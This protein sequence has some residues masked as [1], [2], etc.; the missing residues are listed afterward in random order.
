MQDM[1]IGIDI[2]GTTVKIGFINHIGEIIEKWE[3]KTNKTNA[4][5]AIVDDI[6]NAINH[7]FTSANIDIKSVLGIGVG[8][9]GFIDSE[10]GIVFEAVNIGWKNF[11]LAG[12][13]T[14]KSKL[15]VFVQ[16]DANI[17]ALGENWQGAGNQ[18]KNIIAVTLGTGVGGGIIVNGSI[19][20]G[21]NGMAGE[22]GH[23]KVDPNGTPCNCGGVGCL[24]TIS[25][26][27]GITRQGM[28]AVAL[29]PNSDLALLYKQKGG[30]SARDIFDL[31][32]S[33]DKTCVH[34]VKKTT[35]VLGL[36]I[37]NIATVINP[38]V[39]LIGGGVSKAGD[40]LITEITTAFEK[41]AIPNLREMCEIKTA[42][43][44]NDAGIIGGAFLVKQMLDKSN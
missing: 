37:A 12:Q 20:N 22:I 43:L 41:Y 14:E 38:S 4:G 13:L 28:D 42:R 39:I 8:A 31:A 25:S 3:I 5:H 23:I 40:Y 19:L 1:M 26:A 27:T 7:K 2:G 10:T 34:I 21:E 29:N 24:E 44:G 18:A 15:P 30:L 6:W 17:A 33:G 32:K 36:A 16:N 9:P 35:D 11:D